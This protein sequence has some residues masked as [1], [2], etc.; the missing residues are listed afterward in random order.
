MGDAARAGRQ[1]G[2]ATVEMVLVVAFSMMVLVWF[3][4]LIADGYARGVVRAALDEGARTGSRLSASTDECE[5]RAQ[6]VMRS[7]LGGTMGKGFRI[8]CTATPT[9]VRAHATGALRAWVPPVPDWNLDLTAT[10]Q[11]S[12][13]P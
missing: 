5:A 10:A 9:E 8:Q 4:N 11:R 13:S 1:R 3:S 7:L 2:A 6:E 12:T